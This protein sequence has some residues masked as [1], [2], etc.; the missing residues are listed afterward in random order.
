MDGILTLVVPLIK[1]NLSYSSNSAVNCGA[2]F[3]VVYKYLE[4]QFV[5]KVLRIP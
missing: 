1:V 5:G 3:S 2:L 4:G